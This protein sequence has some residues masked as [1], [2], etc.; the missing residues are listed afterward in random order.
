MTPLEVARAWWSVKDEWIVRRDKMHDR[1]QW[2][3]VHDTGRGLISDETFKVV[4]RHE[5]SEQAERKA[6]R[7]EDAAR[8]AAVVAAIAT[9]S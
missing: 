4:S 9:R 8:G 1:K 3:V 5:T 6:Q 7:L 2:E